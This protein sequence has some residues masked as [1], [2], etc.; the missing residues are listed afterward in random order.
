MCVDAEIL[1]YVK[2]IHK[3]ILDNVS[4]P[5]IHPFNTLVTQLKRVL[6]RGSE[7]A[8]QLP[9]LVADICGWIIARWHDS[10]KIWRVVYIPLM[11]DCVVIGLRCEQLKVVERW[12]EA[13]VLLVK[14]NPAQADC[15]N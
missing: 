1:G 9:A 12:L 3:M 15:C 11:V 14:V 8:P 10:S 7:V 4:I 13:S 5:V 2:Q 6:L